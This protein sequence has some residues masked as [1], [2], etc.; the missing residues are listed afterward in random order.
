MTNSSCEMIE[1]I[2]QCYLVL[3]VYIVRDNICKKTP[4]PLEPLL[5]R[6]ELR[7]NSQLTHK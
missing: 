2:K 7:V 6:D 4:M 1:N 5:K 3:T